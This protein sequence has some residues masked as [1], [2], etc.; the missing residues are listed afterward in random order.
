MSSLDLPSYLLS[1]YDLAFCILSLS[2]WS[3]VYPSCCSG[4]YFCPFLWSVGLLLP[5][6]HKQTTSLL[7]Q[8]G[9]W[10]AS[11]VVHLF[12]IFY[13]SYCGINEKE[14]FLT[15]CFQKYMELM[16][17]KK[18]M[19]GTYFKQCRA[20]K[21]YYRVLPSFFFSL[22]KGS[23]GYADNHSGATSTTGHGESIMKVVLARLILYHME[24]GIFQ[25][26]FNLK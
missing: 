3:S 17:L 19:F 2:C 8:P 24:Q 5:L 26:C 10:L 6:V 22:W 23:G 13:F 14:A 18:E 20:F 25:T 11:T 12:H 9:N 7:S 4:K 1:W 21:S 15:L 16:D